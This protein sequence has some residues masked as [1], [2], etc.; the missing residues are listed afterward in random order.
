VATRRFVSSS[1]VMR[2]RNRVPT[3]P[4]S[5]RRAQNTVTSVERPPVRTHRHSK[6]LP[7]IDA[8]A[9][10]TEVAPLPGCD[11]RD[12][13]DAGLQSPASSLVGHGTPRHCRPP[14]ADCQFATRDSLFPFPL[15]TSDS[16]PPTAHCRLTTADCRPPTR[17]FPRVLVVAGTATGP[18]GRCR[19]H[20]ERS[21]AHSGAR[22]GR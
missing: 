13:T 10:A 14:T 7:N 3:A 2:K 12:T 18:L 16:P 8:P 17:V 5:W 19:R 4:R 20:F 11:L 22:R 1:E 6:C 21:G 9:G 15:A